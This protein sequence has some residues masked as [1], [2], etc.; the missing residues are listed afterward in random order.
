[1]ELPHDNDWHGYTEFNLNSKY[2]ELQL[3]GSAFMREAGLLAAAGTAIQLRVNGV[4]GAF[5]SSAPQYGSYLWLEPYNSEF[6]DKHVPLDSG[7]NVYK[8]VRP[9]TNWDYRNGNVGQYM[10][11][12]WSKSTNSSENDWSDLDNLFRVM[13]QTPAGAGYYPAVS[14]VVNVDQ[15]VRWFAAMELLNSQ[16]TNLSNGADDDYQMVAGI[17]DPRF[18]LLPHDLDTI[19]GVG[20][21]FAPATAPF[22]DAN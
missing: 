10:N 18:M 12:G 2:P 19:L 21:G 6:M 4:N 5:G 16:E 17:N 22:F 8:K 1:M 13:H 14:A 3:L 9:I 20:E 7:G 15:W 11:D